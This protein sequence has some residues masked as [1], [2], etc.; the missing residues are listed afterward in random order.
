MEN[1]VNNGYLSRRELLR[2]TSSGFGYLA[3]AGLATAGAKAPAGYKNPLAPHAGH[4]PGK[5]KRVIFMF[6]SGGPTQHE[7]FDYNA[8]LV[9]ADGKEGGNR[10]KGA[11]LAPFC[12]FN[13]SGKSGLYISELF[14][15]VGKHADKLCL[16]NAMHTDAA[17][18]PQ[19]SI[20]MHT[21]SV[22][23][24]R[25]SMGA[26]VVYGLGSEN[27][28]LPGFITLNPAQQ[29]GAQNYGSAFL[30]APY[31]G[32]MVMAG[33]NGIPNISN[34]KISAE[35]QRKQVDF[36]QSLNRDFL[37]K[38]EVDG[39]VEGV[40][41]SYELAFRMQ[42][43]VPEVMDIKGESEATKKMYG[44]DNDT[45]R[46]FGQQC[47]MARRLAEAGVRFIEISKE[48]WDHHNNLKQ[49]LTANANAIDLPIAGLLQDLEQRGMLEDTLVLWGGEFGR[50]PLVRDHN[51]YGYT[52]WI[53]DVWGHRRVRPTRRG[54]PRAPARST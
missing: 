7:T 12:K 47:L 9:K 44:L 27:E 35:D 20:Q 14:P 24:V 38:A 30:P 1:I 45:T 49:R 18:H 43:S 10:G 15:N 33:A 40:I 26:W 6:M 48:G 22:T 32:T 37:K 23:F 28:N 34:P 21:G 25:P 41:Q 36:V 13:Q 39:Q 4:F 53:A 54:G 29:G 51:P 46:A 17:A 50:T 5:A 42:K 52:M 2:T 11:L 31:Q 3:F 16:L 8:E 19:A